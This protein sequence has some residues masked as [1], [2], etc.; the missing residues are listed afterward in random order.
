M[1]YFEYFNYDTVEKPLRLNAKKRKL[2]KKEIYL[3]LMLKKKRDK[4]Y[5][6][7]HIRLIC[8]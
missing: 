7:H 1:L 6:N 8:Y 4:I 3:Q 2:I 5:I